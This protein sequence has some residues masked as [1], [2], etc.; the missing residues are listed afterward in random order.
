MNH[1]VQPKLISCVVVIFKSSKINTVSKVQNEKQQQPLTIIT[2]LFTLT[3]RSKQNRTFP[4]QRNF[5]S[6][7]NYKHN[8]M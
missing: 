3:T 5:P 7:N 2:G 6:K 8:Q 1:K 4:D